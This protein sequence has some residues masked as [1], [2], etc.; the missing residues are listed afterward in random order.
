MGSRYPRSIRSCLPLWA[1][2][3][4]AALLFLVF[5][6]AYD[7]PLMDQKT[8]MEAYQ[9]FQ[10]FTIR[11]VLG[12]GFLNASLQKQGW[13]S[14]AFSLF[15]LVLAVQWAI[16]TD[17]FTE[18]LLS[19]KVPNKLTSIYPAS[20][21]AVT[22]LIS[23]GMVLGKAN[24]VQLTVMTL[25]EVTAIG[26]MR[27]V[28]STFFQLDHHMDTMFFPIFATYFGVIVARCLAKPLPKGAEKKTQMATHPSLFGMLGTL[29]LW[30]F[31]PSFNS[32][33]LNLLDN[34]RTA[35]LNT[36]FALAVSAVTATSVSALAHPHGKIN[37]VHVHN[38][39]LAGGVASSAPAY[40]ISSPWIAMVLGLLAGLISIGGAKCLASFNYV[41]VTQDFSGVHYTFGLPGLLGVATYIV[42]LLWTSS[43]K[44]PLPPWGS[45]VQGRGVGRKGPDQSAEAHWARFAS[46]RVQV[47]VKSPQGLVL[48]SF[49]PVSCWDATETLPPW[50]SKCDWGQ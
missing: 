43:S 29:F 3:L 34:K 32:A 36:Y 20:M 19:G 12:L 26:I 14:V 37:L 30:I 2:L 23:A 11:A 45:W 8:F 33:P 28:G 22:V 27:T 16:L 17:S 25:L 50:L 18:W 41:Q 38:A 35:L 10:E 47:E 6:T 44:M 46:H 15:M 7:V 21:S 1:L 5:F 49:P 48:K 39:V 40:L 31:W 24:L 42:L 13:S 4:E 9:V